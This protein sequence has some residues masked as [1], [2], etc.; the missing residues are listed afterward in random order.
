[1]SN[2]FS[3]YKSVLDDLDIGYKSAERWQAGQWVEENIPKEG[4]KGI[5]PIAAKNSHNQPTL[6]EAGIGWQPDNGLKRIYRR[7]DN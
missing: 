3:E 7:R 5:G 2:V 6:T 1:M 4:A